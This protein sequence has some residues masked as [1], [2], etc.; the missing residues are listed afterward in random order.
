MRPKGN[1]RK[2]A[3]HKD[4][5]KPLDRFRPKLVPANARLSSLDRS[6]DSYGRLQNGSVPSTKVACTIVR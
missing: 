4:A 2:F 3:R 6:Y 5:K 1:R